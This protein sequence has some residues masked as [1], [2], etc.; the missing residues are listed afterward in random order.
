M[1]EG[2]NLFG[3]DM[4]P[5]VKEYF[6]IHTYTHTYIHIHTYIHTQSDVNEGLNLFGN[7]MHPL[8]K[9]YFSKLEVTNASITLQRYNDMLKACEEKDE[10]EVRVCANV[11]V[12]ECV[13]V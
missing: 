6:S 11:C 8:V 12:C 13:H 1:N 10:I 5:L 3:N 2:L 4:H 7:D 9:E